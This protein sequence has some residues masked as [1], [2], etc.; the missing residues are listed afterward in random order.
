[1]DD[2][3]K[4]PRNVNLTQVKVGEGSSS[5]E[6]GNEA[7]SSSVSGNEGSPSAESSNDNSSK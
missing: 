4:D 1:M 5:A 2:E 6:S 7:S 3:A